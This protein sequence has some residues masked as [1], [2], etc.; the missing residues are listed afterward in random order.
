MFHREPLG[1]RR[2]A[3]HFRLRQAVC[4]LL[5]VF[6]SGCG[7]SPNAVPLSRWQLS[8]PNGRTVEVA[9]PTS[10]PLPALG[11]GDTFELRC[12][13]RL[14]ARLTRGEPTLYIPSYPSLVAL[15][16]DGQTVPVRGVA[17]GS[18]YARRQPHAFDLPESSVRDGRVELRLTVTHRWPLDREFATVPR[19]VPEGE[20]DPAS[21][22]LAFLHIVVALFVLGGIAVV[23]TGATV[24]AVLRRSRRDYAYLAIA[25]LSVAPFVASE[26]G[27][28]QALGF[29]LGE[30]TLAAMGFSVTV[31]AMI[32]FAS[33]FFDLPSPSRAWI[34]LAAV[35]VIVFAAQPDPFSNFKRV[36]IAVVV[37]LTLGLMHLVREVGKLRR[38][39]REGATAL[40]A[41]LCLV[42]VGAAPD[43][44]FHAG[45]PDV[46]GG[47]RTGIVAVLGFM[48][49]AAFL[50]VRG[51]ET[52]IAEATRE[53]TATV[54]ILE[55]RREQTR[56]A[57]EDL[58]R[59]V[60][61]RS[62]HLYAGLAAAA[63]PAAPPPLEKGSELD[64]SYAIGIVRPGRRPYR[65]YEA[66]RIES[67]ERCWV[68]PLAGAS[69]SSFAGMIEDLRA[70]IQVSDPHVARVARVDIAPEGF[71]Y[72]DADRAAGVALAEF[73][74][75]TPTLTERFSVLA[76]AARGLSVLHEHSLC[77]RIVS[78]HTLYVHRRERDVRA[79]WV[80]VA[81]SPRFRLGRH[82][83]R[84]ASDEAA[85]SDSSA[86]SEVDSDRT[87]AWVKGTGDDVTPTSTPYP[88]SADHTESSG[89]S[90]VRDELDG[91]DDVDSDVDAGLDSELDPQFDPPFHPEDSFESFDTEGLIVP[92]SD[93]ATERT[94]PGG[95]NAN[96]ALA[97]EL[98]TRSA[99]FT[100][101]ADVFAFARLAV[102]LL[103][104]IE[105]D[106]VSI[107][108]R[109]ESN[110]ARESSD[111]RAAL[112]LVRSA[113]DFD[114]SRRPAAADLAL[115]LDRASRDDEGAL[116]AAVGNA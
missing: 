2:R 27:I 45:L 99:R 47:A 13:V 8:T 56:A 36:A 75:S 49:A 48:W 12:S 85:R 87:G 7:T 76:Q 62:A 72:V 94:V 66:V 68:T 35:P 23:A 11:E 90:D 50:V 43:L 70:L 55:E 81:L 31:T 64:G 113:L 91:F 115:A 29:G 32:W 60:I 39:G 30:L 74:K 100:P 42:A 63:H 88:S 17:W 112:D 6:V 4:A 103:A 57:N 105:H 111:V 84:E 21:L 107:I 108:E 86:G 80:D 114:P 51:E 54:A 46:T 33:S 78:M 26:A 14:P 73:A 96:N 24:V 82:L 98:R 92:S 41:C 25:A 52:S 95:P 110:N 38:E 89:D 67:G 53:L 10:L 37:F 116:R 69:G 77:H 16:V 34:A 97:P 101:A 93:T 1:P 109:D 65:S 3:A 28:P 71:V 40:L 18:T 61:A 58:R 5:V 59:A 104:D 22:A 102:N 44:A 83:E 106:E 79:I 15:T 20:T 9:L 19:I